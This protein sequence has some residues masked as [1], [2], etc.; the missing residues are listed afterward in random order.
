MMAEGAAVGGLFGRAIADFFRECGEGAKELGRMGERDL[1]VAGG[2]RL[3]TKPSIAM[4]GRKNNRNGWM[5]SRE[6][7]KYA[8]NAG[9]PSRK[10]ARG[11]SIKRILGGEFDKS[12]NKW[13]GKVPTKRNVGELTNA[14][15]KKV[16]DGLV[17]SI[18]ARRR[19][20]DKL[21]FDP[22]HRRRLQEEENALKDIFGIRLPKDK[23]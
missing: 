3:E 13:H 20:G 18:K 8:R 10:A 14:E 15:K 5:S 22:G 19:E 23:R 21:G 16:Q 6:A 2:G 1:A 9:R 11:G 4:M 17:N 7:A 12:K